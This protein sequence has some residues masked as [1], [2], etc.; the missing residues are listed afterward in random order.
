M[1]ADG[2]AS[3]SI[4]PWGLVYPG[5]VAYSDMVEMPSGRI[6]AV[7]ERG[8]PNEEY[9]YLT[10]ALVDPPWRNASI[11]DRVFEP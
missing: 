6:A 5:R 2:G 4:P 10:V 3:W 8:T 7:F 11:S 9:R 1:S